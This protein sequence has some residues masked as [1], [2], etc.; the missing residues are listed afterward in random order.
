[1]QDIKDAFQ[2]KKRSVMNAH[3]SQ[4][5]FFE[6]NTSKIPPGK[7]EHIEGKSQAQPRFINLSSLTDTQEVEGGYRSSKIG[8]DN[9]NNWETVPTA[10]LPESVHP[11]IQKLMGKS[12]DQI[13]KNTS[14][15]SQAVQLSQQLPSLR[16]L[17]ANLWDEVMEDLMVDL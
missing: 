4:L 12:E 3:E 11:L 5:V 1:M 9:D 14:Y 13:I 16:V 15:E 17:D 2:G 7:I 8:R 10:K 6:A